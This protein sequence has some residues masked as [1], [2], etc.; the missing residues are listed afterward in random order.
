MWVRPDAADLAALAR[1]ADAG[2]LT[3]SVAHVLPLAQAAQAWR[4]S[5]AGHTRGKIVLTVWHRLR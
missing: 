2:R 5:Q 4:L 3:V 1:L